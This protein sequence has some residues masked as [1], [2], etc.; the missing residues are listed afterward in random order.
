M[1]LFGFPKEPLVHEQEVKMNLDNRLVPLIILNLVVL[2]GF[3]S[4]GSNQEVVFNSDNFPSEK[5]LPAI[6]IKDQPLMSGKIT[7]DKIQTN[8]R[9]WIVVQA[10]ENGK[11]GEVIGFRQIY[12]GI[13][14]NLE[15]RTDPSKVTVILYVNMHRDNGIEGIFEHPDND[16]PF[17]GGKNTYMERIR[18]TYPFNN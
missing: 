15:V 6:S 16:F 9:G 3:L 1:C 13:V 12:P 7:I 10:D 4:I 11:P 5:K 14:N 8:E 18:V 2:L 17:V